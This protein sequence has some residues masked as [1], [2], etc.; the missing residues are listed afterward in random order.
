M[1]CFSAKKRV[2]SVVLSDALTGGFT[3]QQLLE[4]PAQRG[5]QRGETGSGTSMVRTTIAS[6]ARRDKLVQDRANSARHQVI[7]VAG[8][9]GVVGVAHFDRRHEAVPERNPL[10]V[11]LEAKARA[12]CRPV[13]A[14]LRGRI[15]G[16]VVADEDRDGERLRRPVPTRAAPRRAWRRGSGTGLRWRVEPVPSVADLGGIVV[17]SPRVPGTVSPKREKQC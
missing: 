8:Q 1:M 7:V 5:V 16:A 15:F 11:A 14:H 17:S 12:A 9:P 2:G 10:R 13:R 3:R 6:G 4:L